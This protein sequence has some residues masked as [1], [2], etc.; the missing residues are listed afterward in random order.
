VD[1]IVAASWWASVNSDVP[2]ET[3]KGLL[4]DTGVPVALGLEDGVDSGASGRRT[5]THEEMRGILTSGWYR[6]ADAVYFFN[7]FT[8]P[9]QRWPRED[10]NG[11]LRDAA[12]YAAL[13][14]APR[15]HVLTITSPWAEGEPGS[16]R[17]LPYTGTHGVFRLHIGPKPL[18][19]Q[20]AHVE[21]VVPGHNEPL[22]VRV[23]D[24]PCPWLHLAEPQHIKASGWP[25]PEPPRH[26]YDVPSEALSDGYNLI[27]VSAKEDV[28]ITW[29]EISVQ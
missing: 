22:D 1:L 27:E 21:L 5:Q 24:I 3:W 29:V 10:Y 25:E 15:R 7:L 23:N 17:A 14:A 9:Y 26:V 20:Q 8:G 28:K 4:I 12:S 2:I 16:D 19:Q 11:L 18:P 13:C 6:G